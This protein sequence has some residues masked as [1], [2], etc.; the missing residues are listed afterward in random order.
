MCTPSLWR[1]ITPPDECPAPAVPAANMATVA[2][3]VEPEEAED[4]GAECEWSRWL[5]RVSGWS[6]RSVLGPISVTEVA[7]GAAAPVPHQ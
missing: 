1:T 6:R 3:A 5:S 7:G 4:D 2:D